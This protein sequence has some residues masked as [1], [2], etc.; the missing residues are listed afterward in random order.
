MAQSPKLIRPNHVGR[1]AS[2]GLPTVI[3]MP[4]NSPALSLSMSS[5]SLRLDRALEAIRAESTLV[6]APTSL[7][8]LRCVVARVTCL[9]L[10]R[11]PRTSLKLPLPHSLFSNPPLPLAESFLF[12]FLYPFL[13]SSLLLSSLARR[14]LISLL[15]L[16]LASQFSKAAWRLSA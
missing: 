5:T 12:P 7:G 14:P 13:A 8:E 2:Q 10:E 1:L 6:F 9:P 16:P 3:N 15:L 4:C 11:V